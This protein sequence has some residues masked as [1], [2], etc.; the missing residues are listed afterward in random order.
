MDLGG[1]IDGGTK[2][3]GWF[4]METP[5]DMDDE[6]GYPFDS[7]T[8]PILQHAMLDYQ[9]VQVDDFLSVGYLV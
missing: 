5:T 2:F 9:R 3:A 7:R 6:Q 1:S 8:P 4:L